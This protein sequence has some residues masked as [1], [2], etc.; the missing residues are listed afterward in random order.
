M[1]QFYSIGHENNIVQPKS[2]DRQTD[3]DRERQRQRGTETE[4]DRQRQTE[5]ETDRQIQRET[6][7]FPE[8]GHEVSGHGFAVRLPVSLLAH[9]NLVVVLVNE[10]PGP[11]HQ[12]IHL[13]KQSQTVRRITYTVWDVSQPVLMS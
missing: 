4:T 9:H 5:T 13:P 7:L 12:L 1:S 2:L 6:D 11:R 3:R 10:H 8:A